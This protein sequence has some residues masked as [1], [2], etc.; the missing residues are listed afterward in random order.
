MVIAP[1]LEFMM[2]RL[3]RSQGAA[4][5]VRLRWCHGPVHGDCTGARVRVS[6]PVVKSMHGEQRALRAGVMDR[7]MVI[8]PVQEFAFR[9]L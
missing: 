4:N 5:N 2:P 9:G 3:W 7:C 1:V 8:A 6:R